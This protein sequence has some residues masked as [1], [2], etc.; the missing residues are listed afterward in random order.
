MKSIWKLHGI[1]YGILAEGSNTLE[2]DLE[3]QG[4]TW[5]G[6]G[7]PGPDLELLGRGAG[8]GYRLL[9]LFKQ[10]LL[11]CLTPFV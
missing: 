8:S 2:L 7:A 5:S 11:I 4:W 6:S 10:N 1:P 9:N 3:L